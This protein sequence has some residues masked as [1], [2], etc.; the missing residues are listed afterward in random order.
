MFT[1]A[2]L[3]FGAI[4]SGPIRPSVRPCQRKSKARL[5]EEKLGALRSGPI[6]PSVCASKREGLTE[7]GN[8][9]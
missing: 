5:K 4:H 7:R 3:L 8:A 2:F 1:R 9:R 6:R